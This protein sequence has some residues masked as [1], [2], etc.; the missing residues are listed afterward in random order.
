VKHTWS[1]FSLKY[2]GDRPRQPAY[3]IK[4]MLYRASYMSI[5]S[6]MT[7]W[8]VFWRQLPVPVDWRQ[9]PVSE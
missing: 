7:H 1:E 6:V 4:L 9:Q 8:S 2:T 5:S 3:E